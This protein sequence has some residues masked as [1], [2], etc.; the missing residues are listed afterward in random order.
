[1]TEKSAMV[2]PKTMNT[3]QERPMTIHVEPCVFVL[4]QQH[5]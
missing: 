2:H 1:M 4:K 5:A 3:F